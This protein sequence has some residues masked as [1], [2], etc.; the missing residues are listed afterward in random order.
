M[1]A[2]ARNDDGSPG[3]GRRAAV[4]GGL[5]ALMLLPVLV[6]RAVETQPSDSS[7][8]IFLA[9]L[10]AAAGGAWEAAQRVSDRQAYRAAC[11]AAL[12]AALSSTWIN[13]AVGIIGS[14]DNPANWIYAGVLAVAAIG[15]AAA[16]LRPGPMALAM[17]AA[18]AAQALAFAGA[19]AAQLG[20]TGP[21]TVFF[22]ALWLISASLFRRA[23]QAQPRSDALGLR[24]S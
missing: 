10:L 8:Y 5:A 4:W 22:C 2:G 16:R 18:A 23:A 14:E 17:I 12:A 9:I 19:W 21:I 1:T 13:L 11:I 24:P 3:Q 6:L 15:T 7:D 20:F